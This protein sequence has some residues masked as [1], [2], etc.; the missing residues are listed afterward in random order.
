MVGEYMLSL[1][2]MLNSF[3]PLLLQGLRITLVL[4]LIA[5]AIS[6]I[7]GIVFGVLRSSVLRISYISVILDIITFV[8][9]AI[10]FYVQLL[11]AYFVIPSLIHSDISAFTAAC[12]SLGLCSAAYVSQIVRGGIN[13]IPDG[14]WEAAKVLGYSTLDTVRFIIIPQAFKIILP[15]L[16]GECDQLLK[17]TAIV[18]AIGVL[19]LT[20]AGR[21]IIAQEMNPLTIYTVLAVVYVLMSAMLALVS[22]FV[23]KRLAN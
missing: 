22:I 18:S 6:F 1:I 19:E 15:A 9:R 16:V 17:S 5:S 3:M 11:I 8:L 13:A 2:T 23:E 4:W 14:Q 12:M 20:G 10:P 21:N 7:L